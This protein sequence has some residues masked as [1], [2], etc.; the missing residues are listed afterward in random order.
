MLFL[1]LSDANVDFLDWEL[2]WKTFTIKEALLTTRSVELVNRKEFAVAILDPEHETYIVHVG[3][4]SSDALPSLSPLELDVHTSRRPQISG[5][6]AEEAPT[7]VFIMNVD[8]ADV[9]S[10]DLASKLLKHTGINNHS[11]EM[12]NVNEFI[13]PSKSPIGASIFFDQKSDGSL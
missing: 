4:V 12:V 3:S 13:R 8:F 9:F 11:I 10:L 2:W 7:K 1:T 6:I 5:L